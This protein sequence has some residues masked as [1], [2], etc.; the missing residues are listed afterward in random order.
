MACWYLNMIF[1][2]LDVRL[3][4]GREVIAQH[5]LGRASISRDGSRSYSQNNGG[6]QNMDGVV[7]KGWLEAW[8][9][10]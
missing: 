9:K 8:R 3:R 4:V 7:L 10:V 1:S 5:N 2:Y 6:Y